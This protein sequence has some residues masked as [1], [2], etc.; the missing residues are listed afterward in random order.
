[1][2]LLRLLFAVL[3]ATGCHEHSEEVTCGAGT[4]LAGTVCLPTADGSPPTEASPSPPTAD[5]GLGVVPIDWRRERGAPVTMSTVGTF[6]GRLFAVTDDRVLLQSG[7]ACTNDGLGVSVCDYSWIDD[8]GRTTARAMAQASYAADAVSRDGAALALVDGS[9][10]STCGPTAQLTGSAGL[11]DARTGQRLWTG[12][13]GTMPSMVRNHAFSPFGNW[14][15]APVPTPGGIPCPSGTMVPVSRTPPV[16]APSVVSE[17]VELADGRWVVPR[18]ATGAATALG[19]I[20]PRSAN[21]FAPFA[22]GT[23]YAPFVTSA[24]RDW[25]HVL[26]YT[27]SEST[28]AQLTSFNRSVANAA[29]TTSALPTDRYLVESAGRWL[30]TC[31]VAQVALRTCLVRDAAGTVADVVFDVADGVDVADPVLLPEA[32]SLLYRAPGQD[33]LTLRDLVGA[34]QRLTPVAARK[35]SLQLMGNGSVV[36][37]VTPSAE[38]W[39]V[40]RTG[41]KLLA[42]GVA[43]TWMVP[44]TGVVGDDL[45]GVPTG[46]EDLLL[47]THQ[48]ENGALALDMWDAR[49][50]ALVALSDRTVAGSPGERDCGS[51]S[52][53]YSARGGGQ[54]GGYPSRYVFF[55][56][57]AEQDSSQATLFVVPSDRSAPPRAVGKTAVAACRAPVASSSGKRV[58]VWLHNAV[59]NGD[60]I[61]VGAL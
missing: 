23:F 20:D 11:Y 43:N 51:P 7:D 32:N 38:A 58:G 39:A 60:A 1:M 5:A 3:V 22:T 28:K 12:N 55:A 53:V 42:K 14:L 35:T 41:A 26:S 29:A 18:P 19:T 57:L 59:T 49:S 17:S 47:L 6:T 46:S 24:R 44:A 16:G 33:V 10:V 2:R 34:T 8:G 27:D 25:I 48:G 37:A 30:L 61:A 52:L 9:D 15:F 4:L 54:R 36:I 50:G 21:S 40:G 56:E 31:S 45:V 13:A